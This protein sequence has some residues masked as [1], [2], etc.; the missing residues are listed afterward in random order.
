MRTRLLVSDGI[1]LGFGLL[2]WQALGVGVYLAVTSTDETHKYRYWF[3]AGVIALVLLCVWASDA[4]A[5][6]DEKR[7]GPPVD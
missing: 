6:A 4:G 3:V 5:A 1:R 2:L 7:P